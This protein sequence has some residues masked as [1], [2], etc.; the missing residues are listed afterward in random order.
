MSP[1]AINIPAR[2]A[3]AQLLRQYHSGRITNFEFCDRRDKVLS[4]LGHDEAIRT[5][6]SANW[7]TYCDLHRHRETEPNHRLPPEARRAIARWIL[8]LRTQDAYPAAQLSLQRSAILAVFAHLLTIPIGIAAIF[9]QNLA[10]ALAAASLFI[11]SCIAFF[12]ASV[13]RGR[14]P[15]NVPIAPDPFA[16][17]SPWPF[18]STAEFHA[19]IAHPTYLVGWTN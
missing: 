4:T 12:A 3:Y 16:P 6:E 1:H 9:T 14:R 7:F 8:F 15:F 17:S 18:R 2:R 19:A 13:W 5:V 11:F 10:S